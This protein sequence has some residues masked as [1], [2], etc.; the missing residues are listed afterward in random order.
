MCVTVT[1]AVCL[2]ADAR[3]GA[4]GEHACVAALAA[5][6][7]R[8]LRQ[9]VLRPVPHTY[10]QI[11]TQ[12]VARTHTQHTQSQKQSHT[13][14]HSYTY[15][16]GYYHQNFCDNM[17]PHYLGNRK[18]KDFFDEEETADE[19]GTIARSQYLDK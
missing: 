5:R 11:H 12:T 2:R 10:I 13:Q 17:F 7:A 16:H 18:T 14:S 15:T 1:V 4:G 3:L 9:S 6:P 8:V 19:S